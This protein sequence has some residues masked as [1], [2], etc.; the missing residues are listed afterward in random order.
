[1]T[2]LELISCREND[3][4]ISWIYCMVSGSNVIIDYKTGEKNATKQARTI[5]YCMARFYSTFLELNYI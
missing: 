3:E 2:D 4:I 5:S 1:V